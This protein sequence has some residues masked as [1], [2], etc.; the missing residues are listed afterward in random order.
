MD[1]PVKKQP[2]NG[3][4]SLGTWIQIGHPAIGEILGEMS[5]DWIAVDCEHTDITPADF[6]SVI[7]GFYGRGPVPFAR[8]KE[9]DTLTIRQAL[10]VGAGGVI[11]PLVNNRKEAEYAV[12]AAKFP[13][14][15]IRGFSFCRTNNYGEDF[16]RYVKEA[17]NKIAVITMVESR[18][19][20]ENIDEILSVEGLDGVFIGPYDLYNASNR[21]Q[22]IS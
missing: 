22:K 7:R 2:L 17:N 15:G 21:G 4:P 6:A 12:R 19:A 8:V 13:P 10:D 16:D 5:F 1:N 3:T 9:N 20:V 14:R 11:V 18:R